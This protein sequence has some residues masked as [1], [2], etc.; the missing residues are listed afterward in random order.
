MSLQDQKRYLEA[1]YEVTK[2]DPR[3]GTTFT[4]LED[5]LGREHGDLRTKLRLR[6]LWETGYVELGEPEYVGLT[7][8]GLNLL[9]GR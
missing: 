3:G 4:A 2:N 8:K 6:K 5:K 9:Q 1:L 7:A